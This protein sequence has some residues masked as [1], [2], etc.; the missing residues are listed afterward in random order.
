MDKNM[1]LRN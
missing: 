1:R